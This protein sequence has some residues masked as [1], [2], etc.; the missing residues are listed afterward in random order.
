MLRVEN[1]TTGRTVPCRHQWDEQIEKV[2]LNFF[3]RDDGLICIRQLH[4]LTDLI[5][6]QRRRQHET[7]LKRDGYESGGETLDGIV[8]LHRASMLGT[9]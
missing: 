5:N 9:R 3:P 4:L 2:R 6:A 1:Q 7:D 8:R